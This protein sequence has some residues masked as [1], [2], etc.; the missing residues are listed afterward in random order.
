MLSRGARRVRGGGGRAGADVARRVDPAREQEDFAES[1]AL[2]TDALQGVRA[3]GAVAPRIRT[4]R[5][6][7]ARPGARAIR[8]L[9][10]PGEVGPSLRGLQ[11]RPGQRPAATPGPGVCSG[12]WRWPGWGRACR[13]A[14]PTPR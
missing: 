7:A 14:V 9:V 12:R 1:A 8:V 6:R 4:N 3:A 11:S 2:P 5:Q 10:G 13:S